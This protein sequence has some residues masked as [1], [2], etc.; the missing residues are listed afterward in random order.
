MTA[1]EALRPDTLDIAVSLA[2]IPL[3]VRGFGPVKDKAMQEAEPQRRALL[4]ALAK[5]PDAPASIAAE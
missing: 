1:L 2:E 4:A 5:S 3:H